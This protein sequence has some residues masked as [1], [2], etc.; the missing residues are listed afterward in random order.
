MPWSLERIKS[1]KGVGLL[2]TLV[3]KGSV[4]RFSGGVLGIHHST[5]RRVPRKRVWRLILVFNSR[6]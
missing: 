2:I 5:C 4:N 6:R 3:S 1:T